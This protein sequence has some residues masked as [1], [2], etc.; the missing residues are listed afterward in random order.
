MRSTSS[1]Y[2]DVYARCEQLIE[3]L[4]ERHTIAELCIKT[5]RNYRTVYR[6]VIRLLNLGYKVKNDITHYWIDFKN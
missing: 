6:D 3:L 4:H 5:G 2:G 1:N